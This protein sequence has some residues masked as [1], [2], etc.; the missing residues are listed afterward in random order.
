M[1]ENLA[2][3]RALIPTTV[4][5][6][7]REYPIRIGSDIVEAF[8]IAMIHANANAELQGR[9]KAAMDRVQQNKPNLVYKT[10]DSIVPAIPEQTPAISNVAPQLIIGPNAAAI[11][12]KRVQVGL[13][14]PAANAGDVYLGIG[15]G[16]TATDCWIIIP[17]DA[18]Q[19]ELPDGAV[20]YALSANGTE[21]LNVWAQGSGTPPAKGNLLT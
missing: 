6:D 17:S 3:D 5:I 15:G 1:I 18:V 11:G 4:S 13:Q 16:V 9:V 7:G 2:L 21:V 8:A 14:A 10:E 12:W 20:L 19:I